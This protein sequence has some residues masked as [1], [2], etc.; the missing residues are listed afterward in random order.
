M[1]LKLDRSDRR[2]GSLLYEQIEGHFAQAIRRGQ[3]RPNSRLPGTMVLAKELKISHLTV[4]KAYE[5]LEAQGLVSRVQGKGT[6]VSDALERPVLGMISWLDDFTQHNASPISAAMLLKLTQAIEADGYSH[7]TLL[8][9]TDRQAM[10]DGNWNEHDTK[11][12]EE[13]D[14]RGFYITGTDL[15][16]WFIER[17]RGDGV[18]LVGINAMVEGLGGSVRF[19]PHDMVRLA[20]AYL[21][22]R[23][24]RKPTIIFLDTVPGG[25]RAYARQLGE[26]LREAGGFSEPVQVVGV[27]QPTAYSGRVAMRRLL[28]APRRVD[29]VVCLDDIINQGVCWACL[30]ANVRVPDELVLVSHANKGVTPPFLVPVA[31]LSCD[32]VQAVEQAQQM[33]N[34]L[35]DKQP[36][37]NL[38][39]TVPPHLTPEDVIE[40]AQ[41]DLYAELS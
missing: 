33:M 25:N 40:D 15:P 11:L 19:H 4:R 14:L 27:R 1:N 21:R 16:A 34:R 39:R 38:P 3:F 23:G 31:R 37:D 36:I 26:I 28:D 24:C 9:T 41:V 10:Y 20:G 2:S 17:C 6:I 8:L 35:L 29:S 32:Y 5:R 13:A 12:L 22:E 7:R 18:P 30:E